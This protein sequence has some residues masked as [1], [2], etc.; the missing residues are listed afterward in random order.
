MI[1][2]NFIK[3]LCIAAIGL[4]ASCSSDDSAN[5]NTKL[6]PNDPETALIEPKAFY[7]ANEDWFGQS[8]GSI[9]AIN[10]PS[11]TPQYRIYKHDSPATDLGATLQYATAYADHYFAVSK[12]GNRLVMLDKKFNYQSSLDYIGNDGRAFVGITP[13]KAYVSTARGISLISIQDAI[14]NLEGTIDG[15]TSQV[16]TMIYKNGYVYAATTT[17]GLIIIDTTTDKIVSKSAFPVYQLTIDKQGDIW[18]GANNELRK[19]DTSLAIDK[20]LDKAETIDISGTPI[21]SSAGAWNAGSLS[22]SSKSDALYWINAKSVV[23]F[24]TSTLA[25]DNTFHVL[26]NDNIGMPLAFYGAGM[27]INPV[28]D[29]LVLTIKRDGWGENG[30]YNW[31]RVLNNNGKVDREVRLTGGGNDLNDNYYWFPA[32]PFFEDNNAPQIVLNQIFVKQGEVKEVDLIANKLIIDQD[33]NPGLF[34]VNITSN[35]EF[36]NIVYNKG[37]L[38]ITSKGSRGSENITMTINSNGKTATKNIQIVIL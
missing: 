12:Q 5:F 38:T 13:E 36:A 19:I 11:Y 16:G 31:V 4:T 20:Q 25:I 9:N 28:T 14:L 23:K 8:N 3:V 2:S 7:I 32:V 33:T 21:P 17:E 10:L 18:A 35:N 34:E 30:S 24:N 27:A 6:I 29:Q 22:A 15:I 37:F 1:H 26:G